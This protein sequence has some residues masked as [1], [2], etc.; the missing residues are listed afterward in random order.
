M[1][2]QR[3]PHPRSQL[4][5]KS[6]E[7]PNLQTSDR[8]LQFKK[9]KKPTTNQNSEMLN[10]ARCLHTHLPSPWLFWSTRFRNTNLEVFFQ[11]LHYMFV[12]QNTL[13][14]METCFLELLSSQLQRQPKTKQN[15]FL[16]YQRNQ[17]TSQSV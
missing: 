12:V 14:H 17:K 5:T 9:K 10:T 11:H 4:N 15:N 13:S 1:I 3:A 7:T 8:R 2:H 6:L 16:K